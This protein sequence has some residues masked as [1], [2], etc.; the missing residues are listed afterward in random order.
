MAPRN[1]LKTGSQVPKSP[2]S[3]ER[4]SFCRVLSFERLSCL[5]EIAYSLSC[6]NFGVRIFWEKLT[7]WLLA[8]PSR[9]LG[10]SQ[11]VETWL[12]RGARWPHAV[13]YC[14]RSQQRGRRRFLRPVRHTRRR[15]RGG[16]GTDRNES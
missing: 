6:I 8:M 4:E 10:E 2:F 16:Q 15:G 5:F 12:K 14:L 13:L 7:T 1:F 3:L 11:T 9:T